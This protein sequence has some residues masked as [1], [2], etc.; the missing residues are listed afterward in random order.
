MKKVITIVIS[1]VLAIVVLITASVNVFYYSLSG[2]KYTRI[3]NTSKAEQVTATNDGKSVE[4][5]ND[6][7]EYKSIVKMFN[8]KWVKVKTD[9]MR[10]QEEG[11]FQIDIKTPKRTYTLLGNPMIE[12]GSGLENKVEFVLYDAS[13]Y[14]TMEYFYFIVTV[15][16]DDFLK[17]FPNAVEQ[18]EA[19]SKESDDNNDKFNEYISNK[20]NYEKR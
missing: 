4:F 20:N 6:S 13:N 9:H 18:I 7:D 16:R 14:N 17:L 1:V 15:S 10:F 19:K 2:N 8:H 12:S 5:S 3:L 11:E